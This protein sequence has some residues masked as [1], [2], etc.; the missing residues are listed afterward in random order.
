MRVTTTC[1]PIF[2]ETLPRYVLQ[3]EKQIGILLILYLRFIIVVARQINV[4]KFKMKKQ[5]PSVVE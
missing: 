1:K 2:R 5:K 4:A 3:I